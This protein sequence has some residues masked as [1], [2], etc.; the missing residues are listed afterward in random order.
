MNDRKQREARLRNRESGSWGTVSTWYFH[1]VELVFRESEK[2][3][4]AAQPSRW[5]YAGLPV[6]I[7]GVE[8][9]LIE[10]QQMLNDSSGI[11]TLA[12]VDPIREVL[13]LYPLPDDLR[14]DLDALIEIRN[15]I[16][17]PA[18]VPF[19]KAEWPDS[20]QRLRERKVLDGN[21]PQSGT[22][23]LALLEN[24]RLFAWAVERCAETLDVVADSD[25]ERS[26]MFRGSAGNL[27]RV[28]KPAAGS[29]GNEPI[30]SFS[31]P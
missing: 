22:H 19:G 17:H 1:C 16:V 3:V 20:L 15:L 10:H 25:P 9:F 24:H 5:V 21:I 12:G 14:R 4:A 26:L 11:Q 31:F 28:L 30:A 27:W 13:K 18:Q 7:S 2:T 6:L 23:A 29:H 8:A